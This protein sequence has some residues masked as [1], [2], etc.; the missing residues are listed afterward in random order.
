MKPREFDELVRRKFD[1][2]DFAYNPAN[3]DRLAEELDGRAKKRSIIMWWWIPLAGMAASVALAMGVPSVMRLQQSAPAALVA[4]TEEA[5]ANHISMSAPVADAPVAQQVAGTTALPANARIAKS[6][7]IAAVAVNHDDHSWMG[8]RL[9]NALPSPHTGYQRPLV[10]LDERSFMYATTSGNGNSNTSINNTTQ[11]HTAKKPVK[12]EELVKNEGYKTF[13]H[14]EEQTAAKP[15]RFSIILN[16]GI[17]H[18]SQNSGYAA[19]ATVRKMISD[20]V[21]IESDV[22]FASSDNVQSRLYQAAGSSASASSSVASSSA[23]AKPAGTQGKLAT[24]KGSKD[25]TDG[26]VS[27]VIKSEDVSYSLYYA[28]VTPSIGYKIMKRMSV[29]VGPDFQKMLVDNRPAASTVDKNTIQVAPSFDVGFIGK[30]EYAL[31]RTVHAGV[32]YRKGVNNVI[33]P[34]GKYIDRDYLQFQLKCAIF[35]K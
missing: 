6:R 12:P 11:N 16:G 32:S 1:Q 29:G 5:P 19:G 18:G 3:W 24:T 34:M 25:P 22:A 20:K 2:D 30:T 17:S 13:R 33:T 9:G 23:L 35:N 10:K 21:Y 27:P 26:V 14:E 15:A 7:A 31:T 8:I 4:T 28:Q